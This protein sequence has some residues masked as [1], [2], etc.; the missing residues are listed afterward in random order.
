VAGG[1]RFEVRWDDGLVEGLRKGASDKFLR[2]L[3][4][5][6]F[7]PEAT[8]DLHGLRRA[9]AERVVHDFV[10]AEHRRGVRYLLIIVGK[11]THSEDG[12]GVLA[13]AAV[14]ALTQGIAAPLV[15][16]FATADTRHGGRGA[17]AVQLG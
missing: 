9:Q 14:E 8:L 13:E 6:G 12:V 2:R 3:S 11:G 17:L 7:E 15:S 16:A 1:A 4:G 10:R 5:A